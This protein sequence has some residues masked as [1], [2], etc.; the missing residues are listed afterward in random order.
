MTE[1]SDRPLVGLRPITDQ[2]LAAWDASSEGPK[3]VFVTGRSGSGRGTAVASLLDAIKDRG[4]EAATVRFHISEADDGI[5]SLLKTYG[6]LVTT[7]TRKE[8]F[9]E[10]P[11]T[12][13]ETA[14]E[15]V[16]DDKVAHWLSGIQSNVREFR[17]HQ[18]GNFQIR[19]PPENPY[20]GAL[21]AFDVLGPHARWVLD[22]RSSNANVSP[23][24]W[25]FL[26]ALVGRARSRSW[27]MLFLVTPGDAIYGESD[28]DELPG[29]GAFQRALF[30]DASLL[31]T[32]PL[33][34]EE[35]TEFVADTYRP[36]DF[37]AELAEL[38]HKMSGGHPDTLHELVDAL[39]A[40]GEAGQ[41]TPAPPVGPAL[42]A[43][44]VNIAEFVKQF[45]DRTRDQMG[46]IIPIS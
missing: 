37:P 45:N 36:N 46:M 7:L 28:K 4:D 8:P 33:S 10:D 43:H 12:L 16:A 40:A 29:P 41:A 18:S 22:L 23:A 30:P 39:D 24:F 19:L 2:L 6:S 11:V 35:V 14:I 42:G 17:N 3:A 25:T 13:L 15:S 34:A 26:A 44:G 32:T 31:E 21:Y 20:V 38:L 9:A 5:Q 27:K 1:R